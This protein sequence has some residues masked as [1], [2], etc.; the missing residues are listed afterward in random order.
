MLTYT[1]AVA[2][3][4]NRERKKLASNTYLE[5]N[6]EHTINVV[7]HRTAI[8]QIHDNG[9]Y[10]LNSGGWRTVTTKARI[11][12]YSP[13]RL[14]QSNNIWYVGNAIFHDGIVVDGNGTPTVE[15]ANVAETVKAKR[16]LDRKVNAYIK[17]FA[18][19]AV[20]NGGL[21]APSNGDCWGCLFKRDSANGEQGRLFSKGVDVHADNPMGFDHLLQHMEENYFVPSLLHKAI[22]AHGYVN[23]G[24]IWAHIDSDIKAGRTDSL[25]R[26]LR[27][28]FTRLKPELLKLAA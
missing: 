14:H 10:T 27:F 9:T 26:E 1:Q 12:D 28:Y 24:I 17:A 19:D 16:A 6:G 18:A 22:V 4:G 20:A 25:I 13:A 23:P 8:V 15:T 7:L 2:K 11:N 3:L 5:R 21:T